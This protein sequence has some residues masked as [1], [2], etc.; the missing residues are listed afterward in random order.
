MWVGVS[1]CA[2]ENS[3]YVY[4]TGKSEEHNIKTNTTTATVAATNNNIN[5]NNE[6]NN[7]ITKAK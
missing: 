1:V 5:K 4:N 3:W 7:E 2:I 6:N